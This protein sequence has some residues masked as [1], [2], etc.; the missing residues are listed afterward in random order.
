MWKLI[1]SGRHPVRELVVDDSVPLDVDT[2]D[3]YRR[4]VESVP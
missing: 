4:L 3:D 1:Q 2:W